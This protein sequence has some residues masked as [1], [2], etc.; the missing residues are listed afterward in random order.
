MKLS[1]KKG[2]LIASAI[3][4]ALGTGSAFA[5]G[6]STTP[7]YVL[8]IGGGSAEPQAIGVTTCNLMSNVDLYTDTS[9]GAAAKSY[10]MLYGTMKAASP[11]GQVPLGANVLVIYKFNGGSLPNGGVPQ[12]AASTGLPYPT[13]ASILASTDTTINTGA[14]SFCTAGNGVPTYQIQAGTLSIESSNRQPSF[15]LTDLEASAFVGINNPLTPAPLPVVGAHT[16]IYDLVFGIAVSSPL[17]AQKTNF[18]YSEIAGILSAKITD[19]SQLK[20]DSGAPLPA[21]PVILL[22]RNVGS[23]HKASS[24]AEFL[25]YPQLGAGATTPG[26]VSYGYSGGID[27]AG[28]APVVCTSEYQD[29]QET[30]AAGTV[31]DLKLLSASG[32]G[33][34]AVAILSMDNPPGLHANQNTAGTN[35]YD[36]VALNGTWVDAHNGGSDDENGAEGT[37][38]DNVLKGNYTWYY[39]AN[40]N[41]QAGFL[42][43]ATSVPAADLA[44]AYKNALSSKTL[45]GCTG[46]P[47]AAF[48]GNMSGVVVDGDEVSSLSA[49]VTN[50]SR[51]GN[52]DKPLSVTLDGGTITI[53][54]EPL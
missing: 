34:R 48:P 29:V 18:S 54:S 33:L 13:V 28:T 20:G 44:T 4:A 40:F 43:T 7:N 37:G 3:A 32:C 52:S 19:W 10:Y 41:T 17:F 45:P 42:G 24:S 15:G 49:C 47:G 11:N 16:P 22:D 36:F 23:G 27:G 35:A 14:G 2:A 39:Q 6:P 38:Y 21:G 25:G 50:S 51:S 46:S 9:G 8:Y 31:S 5:V 12:S 30:A 1:L 53:G 26:S